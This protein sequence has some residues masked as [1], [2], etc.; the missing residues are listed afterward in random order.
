MAAPGLVFDD[1]TLH[2]FVQTDFLAVG[3]KLEHLVSADGGVRFERVDT[4]LSAD[5]ACGEAGMFDAHPC[6]VD[7]SKF[8]VYTAM[9]E[10]LT[11]LRWDPMSYAAT[12]RGPDIYLARSESDSWDGPWRRLGPIMRQEDVPFHAPPGDENYEWGLEGPQLVEL[13]D[14]RVLLLAVC[15]VRH[16][17]RGSRQRLYVAVADTAAGPYSV[18]GMP[19]QPGFAAWESGEVGHGAFQLDGDK[20]WLFYQARS[21]DVRPLDQ[22]EARWRYGA[23][24]WSLGALIAG[25]LLPP[26][27]LEAPGR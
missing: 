20:L 13:A 26:A 25:G 23:A 18:I 22:G 27:T 2:M 11:G 1:G 5:A 10:D 15:F 7:G 9:G 16:H 24:R 4:A 17:P 8:L 6:V 21:R 14:G 19:L 12:T 3:G